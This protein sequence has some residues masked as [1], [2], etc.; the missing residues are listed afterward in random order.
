MGGDS[1]RELVDPRQRF[2]IEL[3]AL[4]AKA[5]SD[6]IL[7]ASPPDALAQYVLGDAKQPHRRL[8]KRGVEAIPTLE[9][10][11]KGLRGEVSG[12][13]SAARPT[14]EE[15]EDGVLIAQ[16]EA[17]KRLRPAR[18]ELRVSLVEG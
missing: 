15:S 10:P 4:K 14:Q 12:K 2:V 16:I 6:V 18:K 5:A 7:D 17:P 8:A 3:K 1:I 11:C 9:R 13:L